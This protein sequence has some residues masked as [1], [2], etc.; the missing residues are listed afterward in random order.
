MKWLS[1]LLELEQCNVMFQVISD[2]WDI[3]LNCEMELLLKLVSALEKHYFC[4]VFIKSNHYGIK[5]ISN[6]LQ[7]EPCNVMFKV[8]SDIMP[9]GM[10][11][12]IQLLLQLISAMLRNWLVSLGNKISQ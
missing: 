4:I 8:I 11:C 5:C 2:I 6:L 12:E 1:N 3:G 10:K 9:I 7:L